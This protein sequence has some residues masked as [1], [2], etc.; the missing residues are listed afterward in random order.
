MKKL[1]SALLPILTALVAIGIYVWDHEKGMKVF[2]LFLKTCKSTIPILVL[3]FLLL[4][5]L[6]FGLDTSKIQ[7]YMGKEK[8]IRNTVFAFLFGTL[9]S[10]PIYPGYSLGNMLIKS[11]VRVNIVIKM[12]SVWATLKIP[13][14]PYEIKILGLKL[15]VIRWVVTAVAIILLSIICE[16]L[17]SLTNSSLETVPIE[18]D[19]SNH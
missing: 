3:M 13:L 12:L 8:G 6:K 2:A 1:K 10:G 11:G 14:L 5:F 17:Y 16:K 9:V 4:A 7:K 19:T 18:Q 15:C